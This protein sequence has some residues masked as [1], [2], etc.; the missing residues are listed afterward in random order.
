MSRVKTEKIKP[1]LASS[2]PNLSF[3]DFTNNIQS[4]GSK[5]N[6]NGRVGFKTAL[7]PSKSLESGIPLIVETSNIFHYSWLVTDLFFHN[8]TNDLL[9]PQTMEKFEGD[10]RSQNN[11]I[12]AILYLCVANFSLMLYNYLMGNCAPKILALGGRNAYTG[13]R[14]ALCTM[15]I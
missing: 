15:R 3:E 14:L 1:F 12:S 4:L 11:C 6:A 9:T 7:I 10:P 2:V 13:L 8:S 5:L